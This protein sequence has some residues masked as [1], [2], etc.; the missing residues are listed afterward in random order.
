MRPKIL[1]GILVPLTSF[2]GCILVLY[3]YVW[4]NDD[5]DITNNIDPMN[6]GCISI[7]HTRNI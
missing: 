2:L 4:N 6:H 5:P 7:G 1:M 3:P